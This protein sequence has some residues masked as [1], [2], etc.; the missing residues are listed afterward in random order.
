MGGGL[1]YLYIS[2]T[3]L[4][5][6]ADT[7]SHVK[8]SLCFARV[9]ADGH[10]W[11]IVMA[12]CKFCWTLSFYLGTVGKKCSQ[13]YKWQLFHSQKYQNNL[14]RKLGSA[15]DW[16]AKVIFGTKKGKNETIFHVFTHLTLTID[17]CRNSVFDILAFILVEAN[18]WHLSIMETK[19]WKDTAQC[20]ATREPWKTKAEST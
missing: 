17:D 3:R 5:I 16:A 1:R 4:N 12:C 10:A 13:Q 8:C 19:P 14:I 9:C 2:N 20:K 7:V 15:A 11:F 18:C 6:A